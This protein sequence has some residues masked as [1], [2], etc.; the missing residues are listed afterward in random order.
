MIE[1]KYPFSYGR[2]WDIIKETIEPS[3]K[4]VNLAQEGSGRT[5]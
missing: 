3:T 5:V 2:C 1:E 4:M